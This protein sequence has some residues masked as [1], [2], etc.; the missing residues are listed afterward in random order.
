MKKYIIK[1]VSFFLVLFVI[2][3]II[4]RIFIPKN[5][6]EKAGMN[7]IQAMTILGEKSNTIDVIM[8]GDS[9]SIAS[10]IP[11]YLWQDY[12]FTSFICGTSGQTLPDTC[13]IAF[14]TL[15]NQKPKIVILEA[16]TIYLPTRITVPVSRI[17]YN[18]IF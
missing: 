17:I 11:I 7:N 4:S 1:A 3:A 13:R 18:I 15:K 12:G 5:N 16:D 2:L 10:T 8:Y 9:E 6:S 14:D